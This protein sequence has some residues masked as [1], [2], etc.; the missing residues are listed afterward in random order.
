MDIN[1]ITF[2]IP[3]AERDHDLLK[4]FVESESYNRVANK[5]RNIV[6]GNRGTGKSAIF[7]KISEEGRKS[8][9]I[10]IQL[11]PD[12]YSYEMMAK[13]L[14]SEANGSW[15]KHG[16]YSVAWKYLIYTQIFKELSNKGYFKFGREAKI[17]NYVRDNIKDFEANPIGILISFLKRLEG[18]KIGKYEAAI[19]SKELSRLYKLDEISELVKIL[20]DVAKKHQVI[21]IVDE[22]DKGWDNS[23]DAKHF[24]SGLFNAA[25]TINA[26]HVNIRILVSLRREL[27]DNIPE[28]YEDYQKFSDTVEQ[29]SWTEETL[30]DFIKMRMI[31]FLPKMNEKPFDEIWNVVFSETLSYRST[32]SFNY[33]VDRTLFRP[34]EIIQ[35]ANNIVDKGRSERKLLPLDY[36]SIY[37]AESEYSKSRLSDIAAEYKF[38]YPGLLALF[39]TFR[40]LQFNMSKEAFHSHLLSVGCGE[41][42]LGKNA[43][44]MR[45]KDSDSLIKVLWEVGFIKAQIVGGIKAQMRHGS[46]WI[47]SYQISG[48]N[49]NNIPQYQVHPM[50]RSYLGM[51]ESKSKNK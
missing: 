51:K 1:Q 45:G 35:F 20:D 30:K 31:K 14:E 23:E 12:E 27:Y 37:S 21:V 3:A 36:D 16:A 38:Q 41:H 50:F 47:G 19:K 43:E 8:G 46:K 34:R 26:N 13:I 29:I 40:G 18:V 48:I 44:W 39:E 49:V 10:I 24:V 33:I 5:N 25:T 4:C 28:L 6:L 15:A 2:G 22:L 9:K 32:K 42:D 11:A 17:Y 7:A